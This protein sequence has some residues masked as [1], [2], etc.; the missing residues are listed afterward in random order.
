MRYTAEER[1]DIGRRVHE[2]EISRRVA[3]TEYKISEYTVRDYV[4][5]ILTKSYTC[6]MFQ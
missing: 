5:G 6:S 4:D 2:R 3:A 1:L